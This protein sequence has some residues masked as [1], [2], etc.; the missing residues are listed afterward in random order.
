M[1]LIDARVH[2]YLDFVVVIAFVLAPF[3][4]GLGGTPALLC[5]GLAAVHLVLTL[6][7]RFPAGVV[8]IIPF[9]VHGA[10]ELLVS[11]GLVFAPRI[12][13]F[14]PGS[15]ARNFFITSGVVVFLVWVLTDYVGRGVDKV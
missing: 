14:A 12:F 15:P 2:G 3:V 5:W 11:V 4:V 7:T 10:I 1:K 6:L 13:G 8:K 9:V